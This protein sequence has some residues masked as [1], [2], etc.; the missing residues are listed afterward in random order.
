M[1][2]QA[3]TSRGDKNKRETTCFMKLCRKDLK[4]EKICI[5]LTL[6]NIVEALEPVVLLCMSHRA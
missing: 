1:T 4:E 5:K 6:V 3:I 2:P